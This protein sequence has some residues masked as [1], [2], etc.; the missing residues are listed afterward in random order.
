M[1]I[2]AADRDGRRDRD[3]DR[4]ISRHRDREGHLRS[5]RQDQDGDRKRGRDRGTG[6]GHDG[7][8]RDDR[9]ET[10]AMA[11]REWEKELDA[12]AIKEQHLGSKKPRK[13][14]I[15]K[16]SEKFRFSFDWDNTDDTSRNDAVQKQP[17]EAAPP[18]PLL[19]F[20]RGF[21][22][23]IDRRD[24]K[25]KAA[26][27]LKLNRPRRNGAVDEDYRDAADGDLYEASD[28]HVDRHWSDK[29]L[30]EM[31]ERDWRI[32]REDFSISYQGSGVPKPM[33]H[34][35]KSKLGAKLLRAVDEAGY[36]KPSP[37]QMAAIPL[38][39]QQRD[40]IAVAETGSGKTAAFALP[41][42]SY[43][44]GLPPITDENRHDGPY[45]LV[46][47]PTRELSE[48]IAEETARLA[49]YLGVRV[50]PVF[51]GGSEKTIAEQSERIQK[52]CEVVVATP[53]RLLDL[54]ERRYVVLN[55]C[56]YVVL[57]EA[58]RMIDMG[59]EPQVASVLA[60]MPSSNLK[61]QNE[62][63]E[64]DEKKVYRTTFMFSATMPPAVERLARTYLRNPVVVTIGT[65]GKATELI[66]QNVMMLK[67]SE[68][69]PQLHRLLRDLRDKT[70]IVFCNTKKTTDWCFNELKNA[71][72]GVTALHGNLTQAERKASLDGFRNRQFNVL[73]ASEVAARGINIPDVAHVIN[74]DMPSSI[75]K[76]IHC[77]GR[78]GRAGKKGVATS[79]LTL[80]NTDIFF[81]LKQ[82][83]IQSNSHVPP[84][85]AKH[86]ASQFKPGSIPERHVR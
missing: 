84:E 23:G 4:Y 17:H 24:Q 41:L 35:S 72:F 34:W 65:P 77:I 8:E 85:L 45:A 38:G 26:A 78:T 63:E 7:G 62:D 58:D 80:E 12:I 5:S 40:A 74:Y 56:N 37:I 75:N 6:R 82:M 29:A 86:K 39:L 31:T 1:W 64:L 20:G 55:Q 36:R 59:F 27:A 42:L 53:G 30:E 2:K 25:K 19:L 9:L 44:A 49:R 48:Q 60:V 52:G 16:P 28:M 57:D 69:M 46:M 11:A 66:T 15:P 70:V 47:V 13:R 3:R 32:F 18:P 81:D 68:K 83:L 76:Y 43:V 61:P 67:E 51:G 54:L 79:F 50:V 73:V 33:R 22:A 71:G 14:S 21:L 10:M